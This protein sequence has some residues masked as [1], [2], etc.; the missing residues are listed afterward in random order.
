MNLIYDTPNGLFE[1]LDAFLNQ[2]LG[3][4]GPAPTSQP[5]RSYCYKGKESYRLRLDLPGFAREEISLSLE[6]HKLTVTAKSE[7]EDAF[8]PELE[9]TYNLSEDID[10]DSINAKLNNGVL[11]LSFKKFSNESMGARNIKIS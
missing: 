1:N 2:T 7:L 10:P 5:P 9:R 11:D 8:L 6:K 3:S 4:F